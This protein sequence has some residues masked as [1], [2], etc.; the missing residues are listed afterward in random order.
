MGPSD[1]NSPKGAAF[2]AGTYDLRVSAVG[3]RMEAGVQRGFTI[4][5]VLPITLTN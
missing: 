4:S 5:L 1:T 2:P 3:Q